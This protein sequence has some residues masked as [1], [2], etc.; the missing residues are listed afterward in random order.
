MGIVARCP[1]LA[2]YRV[3]RSEQPLS[4]FQQIATTGVNAYEDRTARPGALYYYQVVALDRSGN[5]SELPSAVS[6]RMATKEASILSGELKSDAVLAGI[7][8]LKGQFIVPKGV[9]LTISRRR[10]SWPKRMPASWCREA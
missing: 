8:L 2:A 1:D 7:Y 9:S 3:L 6:A 4:G 10:P 5:A